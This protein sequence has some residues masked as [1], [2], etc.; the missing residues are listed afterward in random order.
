MGHVV[1]ARDLI[2]AIE[3]NRQPLCG[4]ND[5]RTVMEMISAI[6]E[7]QRL[8]G[9]RDFPVARRGSTRWPGCKRAMSRVEIFAGSVRLARLYTYH[10]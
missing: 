2:A 9:E 3:M 4:M 1:G 6:F 5:G 7:S 10:R 8:G